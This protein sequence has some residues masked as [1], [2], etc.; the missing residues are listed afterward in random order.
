MEN[1]NVE[2]TE[3]LRRLANAE[4]DFATLVRALDELFDVLGLFV[5]GLAKIQS[6]RLGPRLR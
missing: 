4:A 6:S 2:I 5:P 1:R 3:A